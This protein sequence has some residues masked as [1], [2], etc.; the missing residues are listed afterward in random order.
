[1]T[2]AIRDFIARK[3]Q[4]EA[5]RP[6]GDGRDICRRCHSRRYE[7]DPRTDTMPSTPGHRTAEGA[8][9]SGFPGCR[10]FELDADATL[11]FPGP[12]TVPPP[13]RTDPDVKTDAK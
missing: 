2:V 9:L 12:E 1:M 7:H 8:W 5:G 3:A 11:R 10:G 13:W 6:G 4:W